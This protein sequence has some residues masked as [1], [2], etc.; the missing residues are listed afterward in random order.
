MTLAPEKITSLFRNY[1]EG[2]DGSKNQPPDHDWSRELKAD[3]TTRL[4][5]GSWEYNLVLS[6]GAPI[7]SFVLS[8]DSREVVVACERR[9][10]GA[11]RF[12]VAEFDAE[13]SEARRTIYRYQVAKSVYAELAARLEG[14]S[15]S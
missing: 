7:E 15:T 13:S 9:T 3:V 11:D 12:A 6:D 5:D 14:R 2:R 1:P 8:H 4:R 10:D